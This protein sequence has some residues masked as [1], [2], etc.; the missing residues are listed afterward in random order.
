MLSHSPGMGK[1]R[2]HRPVK[3]GDALR[4]QVELR[5][6]HPSETKRDRDYGT[7]ACTMLNQDDEVVMSFTFTLTLRRRSSI[8]PGA[9]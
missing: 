8:S 6:L 9:A 3:P 5:E 7:F 4:S 1:I 2:W